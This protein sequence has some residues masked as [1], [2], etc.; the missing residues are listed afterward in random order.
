MED[1]KWTTSSQSLLQL[2][3]CRPDAFLG[4]AFG[5]GAVLI[6]NQQFVRF[7]GRLNMFKQR[8]GAETE[9]VGKGGAGSVLALASEIS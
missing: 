5:P 2:P 8:A 7:S 9:G 3:F 1:R 4:S 6:Q